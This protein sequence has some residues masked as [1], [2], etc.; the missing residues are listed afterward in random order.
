[1]AREAVDLRSDTVTQPTLDMRRAMAAAEVGDDVYREDPTVVGLER[2]SAALFGKE[3]GL[4]VPTGSMGNLVSIKVQTNPG[5]EVVGDSESHVFHFELGASTRFAGIMPRPVPTA[6]G[7]LT[8]ADVQRALRPNVYYFCRTRL[9]VLENT[10][11]MKGGAVYPIEQLREVVGFASS[12]GLAVHL[13]GAR[14][15]NAATATGLPVAEIVRG[16]DSVSF[17]F[18]KGL[19]APVGSMIVGSQGL[20][21][22][23]R[24][25]RKALGGGMRQSGILAAACEWALDHHVERLA[26]D[27]T[28]AR[29]LGAKLLELGIPVDPVETNIVTARFGERAAAV[30]EELRR[31][32]VLCSPFGEKIRFVTHLDVDDEGVRR[33]ARA[34][35]QVLA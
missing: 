32:G 2:R 1:M 12:A 4:F 22:E 13:D 29:A 18:S 8:V 20:I 5:E 24:R 6:R 35:E 33:A 11:N 9:V 25:V 14:I 31:R 28:R 19:G 26:D 23:A 16:V 10:H 7:F 15:F 27:H 3:A 30:A 34:F 21:E 17:C